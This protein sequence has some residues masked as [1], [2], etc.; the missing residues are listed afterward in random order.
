MKTKL[1]RDCLALTGGLL[2]A[3]AALAAALFHAQGEMAGEPGADSVLLQSRLTA[4]NRFNEERGITGAAGRARF[5]ID[6]GNDDAASIRT[7]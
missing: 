3:Q 4:S 7:P 1:F 2:L 5:I 6:R